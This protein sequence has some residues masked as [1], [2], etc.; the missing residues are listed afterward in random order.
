MDER[1]EVLDH[2]SSPYP[3]IDIPES[4]GAV[5]SLTLYPLPTS[6]SSKLNK[7]QEQGS[8]KEALVD[9]VLPDRL[10]THPDPSHDSIHLL[11]RSRSR[12]PS[13]K[14]LENKK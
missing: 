7:N 8:P 6:N 13:Q 9:K 2:P 5:P 14:V 11:I 1:G 3:A 12:K 4:V 10:E